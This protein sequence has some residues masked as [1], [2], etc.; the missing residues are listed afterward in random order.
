MNK[1]NEEL[2]IPHKYLSKL[3]RFYKNDGYSKTELYMGDN[4]SFIIEPENITLAK[5]PKDAPLVD[6]IIVH[7]RYA[8]KTDFEF[9]EVK[10]MRHGRSI[11]I[12][13]KTPT[14]FEGK[15]YILLNFKGVGAGIGNKEMVMSEKWYHG[16]RLGTGKWVDPGEVPEISLG[17]RWGILGDYAGEKEFIRN[18]F[19]DN[20]ISQVPHVKLNNI[21]DG[22]LPFKGISQL[23][24]GLSTNIRCDIA[25]KFSV[26]VDEKVFSAIDSE[27]FKVQKKL[28]KESKGIKV[29]FGT[30]ADNRYIDGSYTDMENYVIKK[31]ANPIDALDEV[32]PFC[33][34][35]IGSA[36]IAM[37]G[38]E[39]QRKKYLR[40]LS[41]NIGFSFNEYAKLDTRVFT[42]TDWPQDMEEFDTYRKEYKRKF[43]KFIESFQKK[44]KEYAES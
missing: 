6:S 4:Y 21:S 9:I 8:N 40:N 2:T 30:F 41:D 22:I 35:I 17:R 37:Q 43:Y 19:K 31:Y 3:N 5:Y 25:S 20:G 38:S 32:G 26:S 36:F 13:T 42:F 12:L 16:L 7:P 29:E 33:A 34:G 24:R 39:L 10:G 15:E 23:V 27:I 44:F 11:D 1:I 28:V 14:Y 18:I